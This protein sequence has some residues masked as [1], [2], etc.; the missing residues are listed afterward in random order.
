MIEKTKETLKFKPVA[1]PC[2]KNGKDRLYTA[3]LFRGGCPHACAYCYA[4]GFKGFSDGG[5]RPVSLEAV[6][7]VKRWPRRL[8][9]SS[10]SDP[11]HPIVVGLAEQVLRACLPTGTF[12][13]IS[14][15]ALITQEILGILKQY[16]EQISYTV[17]LSSLRAERNSLLE[18]NAPSAE[19]RLRGRRNNGRLQLYG[20]KQLA[21]SGLHITLKADTLFPGIDDTEEDIL[22]L[23]VEAKSCGVEAVTFSYAFY[24]NRFKKKLAAIPF[25]QKSLAAMNESQ[26]IASGKGFSLPLTGKRNRL[27]H[28]ANLARDIGYEVIST[29]A[30]KNQVHPFSLDVP[31][32]MDC[33]FHDKWF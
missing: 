23:L 33:H 24:R 28:M 10:A 31:M 27:A 20:V 9:L 26:P 4:T 22:R 18:P 29:C 3:N 6:K 13:V 17:S 1:L 16:A 2:G 5:P 7:N 14:T 32:R 8:F 11:F 30:C 15:K 12:T 21:Q 19:E 25:L